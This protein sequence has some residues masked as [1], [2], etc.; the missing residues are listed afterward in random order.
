MKKL[1]RTLVAW[2]CYPQPDFSDLDL[3]EEIL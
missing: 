2:F 1:F 3:E